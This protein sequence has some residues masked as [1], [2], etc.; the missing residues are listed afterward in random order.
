MGRR[1]QVEVGEVL[2]PGEAGLVDAALTAARVAVVELGLEH[3]G[4]VGEMGEPVAQR[5]L[6]E[7]G[8]LL[9]HGGEV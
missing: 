1:R 5:G 6:G 2:E 8:G 4:E 7:R 9:A 3:L